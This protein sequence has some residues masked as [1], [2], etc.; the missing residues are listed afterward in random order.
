[1]GGDKSVNWIK[2]VLAA[3]NF[4]IFDGF[5]EHGDFLKTWVFL[6]GE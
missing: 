3:H 2:V 4:I 6:G 5:N 1:V